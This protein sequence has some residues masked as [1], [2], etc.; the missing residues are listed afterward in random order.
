MGVV[1]ASWFAGYAASR[2]SSILV[3]NSPR[4]LHRQTHYA[5]KGLIARIIDWVRHGLVFISWLTFH[6][7]LEQTEGGGFSPGAKT[8]RGY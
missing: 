4:F 2:F 6:G 7:V 1:N 5:R 8:L 3:S